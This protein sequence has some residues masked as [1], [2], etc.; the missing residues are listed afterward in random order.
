VV[1]GLAHLWVDGKRTALR[2]NESA[3]IP[4]RALHELQNPGR[5]SLEL[6][7]IQTGAVTGDED[8]IVLDASC[9]ERLQSV[10]LRNTAIADS[11]ARA[12]LA[13]GQARRLVRQ[14]ARTA[15]HGVGPRA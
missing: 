1:S 4:L 5:Q 10:P 14:A 7:E 2:E 9:M 6:I 3:I 13:V 15:A 12:M 8:R 11:E